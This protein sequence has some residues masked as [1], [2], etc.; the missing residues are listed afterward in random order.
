MLNLTTLEKCYA[1]RLYMSS[2]TP[3]G[4]CQLEQESN[5]FRNAKGRDGDPT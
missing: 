3:R 4:A 2:Q 5:C 1:F